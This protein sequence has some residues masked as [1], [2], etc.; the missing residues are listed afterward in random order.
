MMGFHPGRDVRK[1][2]GYLLGTTEQ[3]RSNVM[4]V[5]VVVIRSSH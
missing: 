3:K 2:D 1:A 4:S 5:A